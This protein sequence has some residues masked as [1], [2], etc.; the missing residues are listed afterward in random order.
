MK[1]AGICELDASLGILIVI[2]RDSLKPV[3]GQE[4]LPRWK[5]K[6]SHLL[7]QTSQ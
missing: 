5:P 4:E 3:L 2:C 7:N 6:L 1:G